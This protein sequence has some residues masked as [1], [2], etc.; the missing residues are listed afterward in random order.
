MAA[1]GELSSAGTDKMSNAAERARA[2]RSEDLRARFRS[3]VG[4]GP[5]N[6]K[7]NAMN[8]RGNRTYSYRSATTGSTFVAA[9]AGIK[10]AA[11]ATTARSSAAV[12]KIDGS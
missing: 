1:H 2:S 10:V 12:T 9:R 3:R 11:R 7:A 8:R 5:V 4:A 6:E